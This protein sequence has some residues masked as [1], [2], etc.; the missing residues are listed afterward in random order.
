MART[1]SPAFSHARL[2]E[3]PTPFSTLSR[4]EATH[5]FAR[6]QGSDRSLGRDDAGSQAAAPHAARL[7]RAVAGPPCTARR[8]DPDEGFRDRRLRSAAR[9]LVLVQGA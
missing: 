3:R 5:D 1:F 9:D 6:A 4:P 7:R 8:A 2:A